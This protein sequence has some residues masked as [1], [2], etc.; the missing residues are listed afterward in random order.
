M[1]DTA[2]C[3]ERCEGTMPE[4]RIKFILN[5]L[6]FD[7]KETRAIRKQNNKLAPITFIWEKLVQNCRVNYKPGS[8]ITI[9]G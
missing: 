2:Y 7:D 6:R 9:D 3:G 1:F 4:R 5:C 8:Y